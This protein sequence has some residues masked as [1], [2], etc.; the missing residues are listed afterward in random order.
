MPGVFG[1]L[2]STRG[3]S[4]KASSFGGEASQL[5]L[6]CLASRGGDLSREMSGFNASSGIVGGHQEEEEE[7]RGCRLGR[8]GIAADGGG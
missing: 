6:S 1:L 3:I 5:G 2:S 8:Q 4:G 7:G